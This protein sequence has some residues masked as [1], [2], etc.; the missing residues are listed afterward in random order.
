[1]SEKRPSVLRAGDLIYITA[2]AKAIEEEHV[3]FAKELFEDAG[4][5]VMIGQYCLGRHH[6]FSGT[7][8]ERQAD[9]QFAIDH[10]DVKAIVCARGGY[11]C[12]RILDRVQWAGMLREPKWIIG[13]SDVTVFHQRLQRFG[14]S[15]IHGTMVLNYATNSSEAINTMIS[16][17]RGE[18]TDIQCAPQIFNKHGL[19]S[20]K[21]VGGNLSILYSLLG[22]DDQIDFTDSI[23]FVEDLAEHLY[24]IDRMF[25][26]LDKSGVLDKINGLI[27]GG[28]T[29]LEDTDIPF[30][31]SVEEIILGH[32]R[33]RSIPIAFGFPAGH[34]AD[35]RALILGDRCTLEVSAQQTVLSYC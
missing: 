10:P 4:F 14:I 30:G 1:M 28:M 17:I 23:L 22:T 24:H 31:K 32:F 29:D 27:V 34:I 12:V 13:F 18:N 20:G 19:V 2:P 33:Y 16:A 25:Y 35:N 21:L 5:R 26:A 3:L 8:D 15:S 9:L 6:Y 7:D 11:G